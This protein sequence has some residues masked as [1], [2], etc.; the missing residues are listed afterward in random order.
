MHVSLQNKHNTFSVSYQKGIN[1]KEHTV[2]SLY[3]DLLEWAGTI[4]NIVSLFCAFG[5][6]EIAYF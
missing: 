1:K 3:I 4:K 2:T 5:D 6:S